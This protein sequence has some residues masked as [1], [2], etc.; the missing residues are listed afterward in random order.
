M[1]PRTDPATVRK[2]AFLLLMAGTASGQDELLRYTVNWPSGLSLG[3]GRLE[4]RGDGDFREFELVLDAAV[5]GFAV[6]DRYRSRATADFCSL[7]FEKNAVHGQRKTN[8]KTTFD[9]RKKV[10]RRATVGGKSAETPFEG[11]ARDALDFLFFLRRELRQGRVP[12]AQTVTEGA[13]YQVRLEYAGAQD[14]R[15]NEK[16]MRTD[17]F[18]V[19]AKGPAASHNFEIFFGRDAARVPVMVR[20][21]LG[22]GVFSM[23]LAP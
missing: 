15:V 1:R 6:A 13:A 9:Y 4:A 18:L 11:C 3:E 16:S 23:E 19:T 12:P 21:P 8:E 17:R 5:P 20:A 7:E 14:I 2:L 10:A 22:A